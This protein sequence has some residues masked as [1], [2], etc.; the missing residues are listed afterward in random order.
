M[1]P[2]TSPIMGRPRRNPSQKSEFI[3]LRPLPPGPVPRGAGLAVYGDPSKFCKARGGTG[4]APAKAKKI[5]AKRTVGGKTDAPGILS[6]LGGRGTRS[7]DMGLL[8]QIEVRRT[9][10]AELDGWYR[11]VTVSVSGRRFGSVA[12]GF[13]GEGGEIFRG[14]AEAARW[15]EERGRGKEIPKS[16]RKEKGEGEKKEK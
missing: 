4:K 12:H 3:P 15:M 7:Q 9:P 10:M 8:G 2:S 13:V 6:V 1:S 14:V 16:W 5:K 11:R